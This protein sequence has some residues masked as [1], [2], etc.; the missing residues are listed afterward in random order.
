[1]YSVNIKLEFG[2]PKVMT[3]NYRELGWEN[4]DIFREVCN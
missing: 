1:M 3:L 4:Y 2:N